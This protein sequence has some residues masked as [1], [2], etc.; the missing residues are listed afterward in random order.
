MNALAGG[1]NYHISVYFIKAIQYIFYLNKL[2]FLILLEFNKE[3]NFIMYCIK[4]STGW[5][6]TGTIMVCHNNN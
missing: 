1:I 6:P 3:D 2:M 5:I 4:T